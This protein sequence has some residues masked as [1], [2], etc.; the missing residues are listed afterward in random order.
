MN[1]TE[2]V[3]F[4]RWANGHFTGGPQVQ[5]MFFLTEEQIQFYG[6]YFDILKILVLLY[7]IDFW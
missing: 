7:Y 4:Q 5:Y 1:P 2:H 3:L 6:C